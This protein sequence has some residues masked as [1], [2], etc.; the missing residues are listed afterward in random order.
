MTA[1]AAT[2]AAEAARAAA[3]ADAKAKRALPKAMRGRA[4]GGG[5]PGGAGAEARMA[6]EMA[7]EAERHARQMAAWAR[8]AREAEAAVR[9]SVG[10][11]AARRLSDSGARMEGDGCRWMEGRGEVQSRGCVREG[12]QAG[13]GIG[14]EGTRHNHIGSRS[15]VGREDGGSR[16][17][18]QWL[19]GEGEGGSA[20]RGRG[21]GA[22]FG[23]R[24]VCVWRLGVRCDG[25]PRA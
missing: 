10:E 3:K 20:R 17:S 16:P 6:V 11:Q 12:G 14:Q 13:G 19:S 8:E 25:G 21:E 23:G 15:Q 5:V 2:E 9:V 24:I 4:A 18:E 7:A 22:W 1:R